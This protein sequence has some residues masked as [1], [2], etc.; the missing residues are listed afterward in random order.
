MPDE[1]KEGAET[2]PGIDIVNSKLEELERETAMIEKHTRKKKN[3]NKKKGLVSQER[4]S[5]R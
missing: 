3:N 5:F 4:K 1:G 2:K